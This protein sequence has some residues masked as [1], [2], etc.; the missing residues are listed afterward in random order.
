MNKFTVITAAAVFIGGASIASA[1]DLGGSYKDAPIAPVWSGLY[2]G[3]HL[4]GLWTS[5]REVD[6]ESKKCKWWKCSK[7]ED[8][9]HVKFDERDDDVAFIGGVHIGHNWQQGSRV[10]GIEG[11]VSFADDF[12]YLATLRARLGYASGNYLLY[13][14]F[15]AAF[16]GLNDDALNFKT[17]N[18]SYSF[19]DDHD[20]RLGFVVGGGVEYKLRS[21]WSLGLEG[22]YYG[23]GDDN[24][25][26]KVTEG[27]NYC[28]KKTKYK[29]SEEDDND[30]WV[31]RARLSYHVQSEPE[32]EPLK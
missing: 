7:W 12:D 21:N 9:K 16:A 23:F 28:S 17:K 6:A 31:L 5:D 13:A 8:A 4:G 15:G 22:L 30:F 14:T 27:C 19:D 1:A 26:Y 29:V 11:D 10:F 32:L 24:N 20:Q 25:E 3:G 2:M 18:K